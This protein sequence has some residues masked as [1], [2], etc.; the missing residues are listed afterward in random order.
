MH[1]PMDRLNDTA[2][3]GTNFLSQRQDLDDQEE[4]DHL[5]LRDGG[6]GVAG[7]QQLEPVLSEGELEQDDES[8]GDGSDA[9]SSSTFGEEEQ[10]EEH[11]VIQLTQIQQKPG[12]V[13]ALLDST[14]P[15][16]LRDN[17]VAI[18]KGDYIVEKKT[19]LH[20]AATSDSYDLFSR[21][22]NR[23]RTTSDTRP[24]PPID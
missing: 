22:P 19:L 14:I 21:F 17:T 16:D 8:L 24:T 6:L 12:F 7:T 2:G 5:H 1:H 11:G 9:S 10:D 23:K 13:R 18:I 15:Q 4:E 3:G 20:H